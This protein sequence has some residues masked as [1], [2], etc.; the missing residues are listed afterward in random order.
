MID[1]S[2]SLGSSHCDGI[3]NFVGIVN[4]ISNSAKWVFECKDKQD[5]TRPN[6]LSVIRCQKDWIINFNIIILHN[7]FQNSL[8]KSLQSIFYSFSFS[9][10]SNYWRE[11]LLRV[12]RQNIAG[13]VNSHFVLK[14]FLTMPSNVLPLHLNQTFPPIIFYWRGRW[15]DQIQAMF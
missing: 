6:S 11:S 15:W 7:F 13:D 10:N 9:E 1:P 5:Q 3:A 8:Q 2:A 14:S 12:I 4:K